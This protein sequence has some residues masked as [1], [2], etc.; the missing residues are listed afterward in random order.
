MS[1]GEKETACVILKRYNPLLKKYRLDKEYFLRQILLGSSGL[2]DAALLVPSLRL[3]HLFQRACTTRKAR[4]YRA[5]LG[6]AR[7]QSLFGLF[8]R[9]ALFFPGIVLRL[10]KKGKDTGLPGS[11]LTVPLFQIESPSYGL[12][13]LG[14]LKISRGGIPIKRPK[15]NP[16]DAALLIHMSLNKNRRMMLSDIYRNFWPKSENPSSILSHLLVR[17]K[18]ALILPPGAL[19]ISRGSLVW[20]FHISTDYD[21]FKETLV[22]AK[23]LERAGE[24]VFARKEYLRAFKLFRAEPFRKNYDNWSLDMRHR[25]L[26]QLDSEA[27]GFT[28]SC[29]EHGDKRCAQTLLDKVARMQCNQ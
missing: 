20:K 18:K 7:A 21:L 14:R 11:F 5:A 23:A 19:K 24:W 8:E 10:L 16:K 22:Q 2:P 4:D 13:F 28:K 9:L 29:L 25:I 1:A 6:Y 17:V 3:A 12:K 26:I 27:A 15:L